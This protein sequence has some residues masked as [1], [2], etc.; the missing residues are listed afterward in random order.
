MIKKK[1]AI[2]KMRTKFGKKKRNKIKCWWE[3]LK[4]N[5]EKD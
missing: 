2:K 1:R 3:K 5:Q 4:K